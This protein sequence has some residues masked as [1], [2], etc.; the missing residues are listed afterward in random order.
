MNE[1][2]KDQTLSFHGHFNGGGSPWDGIREAQNLLNLPTP[3][4]SISLKPLGGSARD[5]DDGGE[6]RDNRFNKMAL[7][8][9]SSGQLTFDRPKMCQSEGADWLEKQ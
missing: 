3:L 2:G 4:P 1:N 7:N 9:R 5:E 6:E 8:D